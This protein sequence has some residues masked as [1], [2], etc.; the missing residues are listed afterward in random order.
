[1][2]SEIQVPVKT[3]RVAHLNG[4]SIGYQL[5]KPLVGSKSTLILIPNFGFTSALF[6]PQV[7]NPELLAA[8]NIL[9]LEPIG[10]G[11]TKTAAPVWTLW[12]SAYAFVQAM[13]ALGVKKAF[14][15]GQS[16]GG[17]IAAR[18]ALYA[19]DRVSLH[20]YREDTMALV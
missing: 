13:D 14:V 9:V 19:P 8:T 20:I 2:A 6:K 7:T 3:I 18:M 17:M 11:V 1:M 16:Q 5:P 15:L 4:T 12:D 10:H